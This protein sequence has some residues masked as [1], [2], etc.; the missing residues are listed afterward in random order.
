[1]SN[2]PLDRRVLITAINQMTNIKALALSSPGGVH[3]NH[4]EEILSIPSDLQNRGIKER[5]VQPHL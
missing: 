2:T 5:S 4:T 1:M 3:K